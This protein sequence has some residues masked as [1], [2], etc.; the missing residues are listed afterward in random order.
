MNELRIT[1]G[2]DLE[3]RINGDTLFGVTSFKAVSKRSER[4]IREYLSGEPVA[5]VAASESHEIELKALS[6]FGGALDGLRDFT[7]TAADSDAEYE[8]SGCNVI[9]RERSAE[10]NARVTDTYTIK[11]KTMTKRGISD[12]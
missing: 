2:R 8:Y 6:L 5:A 1:K 11:A 7:L 4:G 12:V 9:G 10:A 3:L